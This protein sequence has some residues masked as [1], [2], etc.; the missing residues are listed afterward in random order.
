M[1]QKHFEG[2]GGGVP[3]FS[4]KKILFFGQPKSGIFP[5]LGFL[6]PSLT[7]RVGESWGKRSG[8][9]CLG[10][11]WPCSSRGDHSGGEYDY[12]YDFHGGGGED[13]D[14]DGNG[15]DDNDNE[16]DHDGGGGD[17]FDDDDGDQVVTTLLGEWSQLLGSGRRLEEVCMW[18]TA[19]VDRFG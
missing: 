7:E 9:G 3:H 11:S 13:D 5:C 19:V 17:D 14:Y 2:P 12:D 6:N 10:Q 15:G 18:T 16:Y 8:C 1:A 4:A